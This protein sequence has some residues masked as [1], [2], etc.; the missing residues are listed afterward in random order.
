MGQ[1]IYILVGLPGSGKSTW[2]RKKAEDKNIIVICKDNIR[3]MIKGQYVFDY[4]YEPFVE[5]VVSSILGQ[6]LM[7]GFDVIID[8]TNI[9]KEKR[10]KLIDKVINYTSALEIEII[11]VW[12]TENK[13]NLSNRMNSSRGYSE[14]KWKEVI[15][16]MRKEFCEPSIGEGFTAVMKVVLS[17]CINPRTPS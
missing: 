8:E 15:E 4:F 10:A 9:T 3:E 11:C 6:A 1:R 5:S 2:C 7:A 16:K 17:P 13:Q 14:Q 12:F